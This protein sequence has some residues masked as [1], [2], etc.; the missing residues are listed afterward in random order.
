LRMLGAPLWF[1]MLSTDAQYLS[2]S[3]REAELLKRTLVQSTT[4]APNFNLGWLYL[5]LGAI[6]LTTLPF[7]TLG[8]IMWLDSRTALRRP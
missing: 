8:A 7:G 3:R 4:G 6:S 1:K 2:D 5:Q